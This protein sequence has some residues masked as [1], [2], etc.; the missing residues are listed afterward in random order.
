MAGQD[1]YNSANM[2]TEDEYV[3]DKTEKALEQLAAETIANR[4]AMANLAQHIISNKSTSAALVKLEEQI[5]VLAKKVQA[6]VN[7][8]KSNNNNRN[9]GQ[10][11][12]KQG[13]NKISCYYC[14]THGLGL[15]KAHTSKTR[16][17]KAPGHQD[18]ATFGDMM[19]GCNKNTKA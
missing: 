14:W 8:G 5:I 6:M 19:C 3:R 15:N 11:L 18:E 13:G 1:R 9:N 17:E 10:R 12:Q 4:E 7:D 2:V 16:F